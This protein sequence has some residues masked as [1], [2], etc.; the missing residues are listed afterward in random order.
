[1]KPWILILLASWSG[2]SVASAQGS[3]GS[4]VRA[5]ADMVDVQVSAELLARRWTNGVLPFTFAIGGYTPRDPRAWQSQFETLERWTEQTRGAVRFVPR[6]GSEAPYVSVIADPDDNTVG[7]KRG[8]IDAVNGVFEVRTLNDTEWRVNHEL[9]HTLGLEHWDWHPCAWSTDGGPA[10]NA[11]LACVIGVTDDRDGNG[12][13]QSYTTPTD[14]NQPYPY[15]YF[16]GDYTTQSVM[17]YTRATNRLNFTTA[18]GCVE[19]NRSVTGPLTTDDIGTILSLYGVNGDVIHDARWCNDGDSQL[20]IGDFNG[21]GQMAAASSTVSVC[22]VSFCSGEGRVLFTGF[23]DDDAMEDHLCYNV[24]S[25]RRVLSLAARVTARTGRTGRRGA[26]SPTATSSS[27]TSMATRSGRP[28]ATTGRRATVSSTTAT[29]TARSTAPSGQRSA[30]AA[31]A[32]SAP[33]AT[34]RC[35]PRTSMATAETL[36]LPQRRAGHGSRSIARIPTCAATAPTWPLGREHL[37]DHLVLQL[38]GR[39][40]APR[41]ASRAA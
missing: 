2:A 15:E 37:R 5:P 34:V 6:T 38:R 16:V 7:G 24:N 3:T 20:Y 27:V 9:G 25:G 14:P 35:A 10:C 33:A 19:P 21:D 26:P 31:A 17:H 39:D 40:A 1:M 41:A 28:S 4:L 36:D 29:A 30:T 13:M 18:N 11:N 32:R 23:F 22:G 12:S 8:M